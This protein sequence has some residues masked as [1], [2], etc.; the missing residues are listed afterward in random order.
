MVRRGGDKREHREQQ[1]HERRKQAASAGWTD[2]GQHNLK[3]GGAR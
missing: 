1:R 3:H 2:P